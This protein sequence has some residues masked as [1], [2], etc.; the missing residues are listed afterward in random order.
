MQQR[1]PRRR[2]A[3]VGLLVCLVAAAVLGIPRTARAQDPLP[4]PA[5]PDLAAAFGEDWRWAIFTT[6]SGLPSN[7]VS[8]LVE[9][10]EGTVWAATL[11]GMAW[12][13][14]YRWTPVGPESG[15]P[16]QTPN[17]L[18]V[19]DENRIIVVVAG[20]LYKGSRE[21]FRRVDVSI[22][23][24]APRPV[25]VT[26]GAAGE[27]FVLVAD[28][29]DL[30][31]AI[32][33]G[34]SFRWVT[35]RLR[36]SGDPDVAHIWGNGTG[37]LWLPIGGGVQRWEKGTWEPYFA[38]YGSDGVAVTAIVETPGRH[39]LASID[40]PPQA[41]GIWEWSGAEAERRNP[42]GA[43]LF[44][45]M[46]VSP[47]GDA[48][49]AYRSGDARIRQDGR[50]SLIEKLPQRMAGVLFV[51]FR[52]NGDLWVGSQRG[53]HLLRPA[54]G[55][56]TRWSVESPDVRNEILEIL[57]TTEG[58]LWLG[59]GSGIA[60]HRPDGSVE[61]IE[62]VNGIALAEITGLAEDRYG[63]IWISSGSALEGAFRWDGARWQHFA[64]EHGLEAPLIHKIR[65]DRSGRLWFLG[66]APMIGTDRDHPEPGAFLLLDDGSGWTGQPRFEPW[67]PEQGLINGRVYDFVEAPDGSRW[68]A[69]TGGLSRW[70][71]GSW[72][73]WT[74][75]RGL[76]RNRIFTLAVDDNGRLW[77]G[78]Q[79][80]GL[81]YIDEGE[82]PEY[83]TT[84]DGLVHD[85][86]QELRFGS[87]GELWI[88]TRGGL[89]CLHEGEW[90]S[91]DVSSGLSTPILWPILP[92]RDRVI[93]GTSGK[94]VDVLS[95]AEATVPP[96]RVD[97][98]PAI[99][100]QRSAL[101]RWSADAHWGQFPRDSVMTRWR[102]D[103]GEWSAW[104]TDREH[105]LTGVSGGAHAFEVQARGFFGSSGLSS[106]TGAFATV[107][108]LYMQPS[109]Y[110][111]VGAL[112]FLVGL[113]AE[114]RRRHA[115][116]LH[117]R[118]LDDRRR[119]EERVAERTDALRESEERLRLLLETVQVIPWV[120]DAKS[121]NFTYVGPQ[122]VD[123]LGYP[124]E[125][126][127]EPTFWED[128]MHPEDVEEALAF[129]SER[130][131]RSNRYEFEYR[132]I[133]ADGGVVW[134]HDLVS[135]VVEN[136]EP[137]TLR[138]FMI[139]ITARKKAEL[140][141]L[142][143]ESEALEHR[144]RLAHLSRV[145][146]LGEMATGIAHEVN[147]PLTAVSTYTQACRRMIDAGLIDTDQINDV[148]SRISE[149]AVR[150]GEMIHG[151]KTLVRKRNSEM[152]FCSVN[153]L[154]LDVI[155]L[156]QVESRARGIEI[157]L[158]LADELPSILAD[159]VQV[160]QVVLNLLRNAIEA[161]EANA[162][163]V[164]VVTKVTDAGFVEV[165]V[166]DR[167]PGVADVDPEQV[168]EP[169]FS[170]KQEGMGM[171]LSISRSIVEAH[172][173]QI[174]HRPRRPQGTTFFFRL[175]AE[176]LPVHATG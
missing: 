163:A 25:T 130:A 82:H 18:A 176:S 33:D 112:L 61:W 152:T 81:G 85:G 52:P 45:S 101:L 146:M 62:S 93:L 156:A 71:D 165:A 167:G 53:L 157:R 103:E 132:M 172:G 166:S 155:P 69:T 170:T 109:F 51:K 65:K 140:E 142:E 17:S 41:R 96:P 67:A 168:F 48:V 63:G 40:Y 106:D 151:L 75:D 138:G 104:S 55:R 148:L 12:F 34:T 60:I 79:W 91:F 149:E 11:K 70:R 98:N 173:G 126:W 116:A 111:P 37:S 107:L 64:D 94:G 8:D 92:L 56:W 2:I 30:E 127:Y 133:A 72:E 1:G 113:L 24:V 10:A 90:L 86:V 35:P 68:F 135:V 124:L 76:Q 5:P 22:D 158:E 29:P 154:V 110:V 117:Q 174:G 50:W 169:F 21:G 7:S 175:P 20:A 13:D 147:Q 136:D 14:G 88:S 114:S 143:A 44:A 77:F 139:D 32:Y 125:R 97:L 36:T 15:I 27:V 150:A 9:T 118:E 159:D 39:L 128:H 129:C 144:E 102:L 46:D 78:D 66:L 153:E 141:R 145:N 4:K 26:E 121:W 160:Q 16:T 99:V 49:V 134:L 100:D 83:L 38:P 47:N 120:A 122:A 74:E 119:L 54:L 73:H 115:V 162:K 108:P 131:Q 95:L 31:T 28:G 89:A 58:S 105:L 42:A 137:T 57:Q 164:D 23:G 84:A 161:T 6:A 19:L 123:V 3:G 80:S 171:G 87:R 43:D 59:T